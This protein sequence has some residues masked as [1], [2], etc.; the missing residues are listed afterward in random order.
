MIMDLKATT[1]EAAIDEMIAK[2]VQAGVIAD[3]AKYKAAILAREAQ[4]TT[5]IGD[6]I[7]MPHA[8]NDAVK[9]TTVLF[10]KSA[11]GVQYDALDGQPVHLFFMIAAPA[12]AN[13]EHL[14]AL[15]TL[16]G[17]LIDADLVAQLK[18]ATMPDEIIALFSAAESA[19]EER[20]AAADQ[21]E[22][23]AQATKSAATNGEK[24]YIVAVTACITGIAHTYM[25]E[26]ALKKSW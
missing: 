15:A 9:Q 26:E 1:K 11:A 23:A 20:D 12:G 19:K 2:D 10:A 16:S 13:N 18:N 7:A 17:L 8:K 3:A 6:G 22:K 14:Q 25:A 21:K 5:G 24:P 4:S